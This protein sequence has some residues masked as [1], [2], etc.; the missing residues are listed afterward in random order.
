MGYLLEQK[1]P[2]DKLAGF[3]K[4]NYIKKLSVFGSAL[5]GPLGPN[6]DIDLLSVLKTEYD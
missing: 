4:K 5:R 2:K 1:M 3:C 6:S